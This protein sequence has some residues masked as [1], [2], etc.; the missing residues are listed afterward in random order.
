MERVDAVAPRWMPSKSAVELAGDSRLA[1]SGNARLQNRREATGGQTAGL[2]IDSELHFFRP[3]RLVDG[4]GFGMSSEALISRRRCAKSPNHALQRTAPRVTVA[5]ISGLDPS[6]PSVA[7][8][9]RLWH[10]SS[11]D[12]AATAPRSAVAE[13]GVV[14]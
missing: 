4:I 1:D 10:L 9:L 8:V 13:L 11:L 7:F 6:R 5:A 12:P 2:A 14:R 3:W